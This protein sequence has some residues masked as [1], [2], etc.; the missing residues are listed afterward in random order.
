MAASRTVILLLSVLLT[1]CDVVE[2]VYPDYD[3]ANADG[4]LVRGWLPSWLP[5][6][7]MNIAS[8]QDLDTNEYS[9]VFTIPLKEHLKLPDNCRAVANPP[10]PIL[11]PSNFPKGIE[12]RK[13]I[14]RC[15]EEGQNTPRYVV[16]DGVMVYGWSNG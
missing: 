4:A 5:K 9:F 7:A 10:T 2:D 6:S 11:F 1:S 3:A 14:V 12:S 8:R 15:P 13:N 16:R